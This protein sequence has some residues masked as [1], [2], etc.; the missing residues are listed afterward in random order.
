[1]LGPSGSGAK[2]TL[3]NRFVFG[4]DRKSDGKPFDV[5]IGA[6]FLSKQMNVDGVY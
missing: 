3:V 4:T 5:T 1:M 2:T 6:A